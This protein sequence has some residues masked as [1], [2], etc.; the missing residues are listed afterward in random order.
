VSSLDGAAATRPDALGDAGIEAVTGVPSWE[1]WL[2]GRR[3]HYGIVAVAD[4][5]WSE[6]ALDG[7]I[8]ASQPQAVRIPVAS[9][10][11][12]GAL[13]RAFGRPDPGIWA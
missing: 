3:Y 2:A 12:L 6:G 7:A 1:A 13:A 10:A 5:R 11:D 4:S 8:G 9:D